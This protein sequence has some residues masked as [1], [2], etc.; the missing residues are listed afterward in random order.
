[1]LIFKFPFGPLQTNALLVGCPKTK[2]GAVVDPSLGSTAPLLAKAAELGLEI[3]KILLTHSHWD[4]FADAHELKTATK[5]TLYVHPLDAKNVISPGSDGLPLFVPIPAVKPD[6]FINE[7]DEIEVGQLKL[8]VIHTPGHSPGGVCYYLREQNVLLAGDTLFRGTMGK[9][10]L[11]TANPLHMWDSLQKLAALPPET[12][13]VP[14]HGADTSIGK[15]TWLCRA[16]EI[17][18]E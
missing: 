2:K 9:L 18:A 3:E 13:V 11:P 5:A 16:K 7:G 15:E 8:R 6:R 12:R 14:G 4:H 10:S 17:F 1:M